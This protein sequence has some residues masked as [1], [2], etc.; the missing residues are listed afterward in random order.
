M[1]LQSAFVLATELKCFKKQ[2]EGNMN[3]WERNLGRGE[4]YLNGT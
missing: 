2:E 1:T 3:N 4:T